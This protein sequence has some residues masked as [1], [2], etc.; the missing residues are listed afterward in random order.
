VQILRTMTRHTRSID[1]GAPPERVWTVMCDIDRWHEWTPSI[2]SITRE[3]NGDFAVG[4]VATVRQPG[5]PPT[6]WRISSIEDGRR[7]SWDNM[8]PGM[9][10]IATHEID[11]TP[12]GC[13]VTLSLEYHGLISA[14][15]ERLTRTRTLRYVAMEADG[16]KRRSENP[17]YRHTGG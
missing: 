15:L 2:S 10:V 17:D 7:F 8:S 9:H 13:R 5:F 16:L 11:P 1:I 4:T 12:G 14:L 3:G 6:R